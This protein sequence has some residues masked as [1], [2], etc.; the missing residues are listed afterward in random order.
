M[1][2]TGD[3]DLDLERTGDESGETP[4]TSSCGCCISNP[5][6]DPILRCLSLRTTLVAGLED[7]AED[8]AAPGLLGTEKF[9]GAST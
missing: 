3:G 1:G 2:E 7:E 8:R 6:E 5:R 4:F 9:R